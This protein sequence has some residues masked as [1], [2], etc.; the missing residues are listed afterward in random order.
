MKLTKEK[1]IELHRAMWSYMATET[2]KQGR[3]IGKVEALRHMGFGPITISDIAWNC[4]CCEY[5]VQTNDNR[6]SGRCD[7]CPLKWPGGSCVDM[8]DNDLEED[9]HLFSQWLNAKEDKDVERA[10]EL[11][12]QI[13]ELPAKD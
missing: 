12:Q 3:V 2:L 11:A 10:A 9:Q 8:E 1:A 6:V 13:A 5:A 7:Y 4:P